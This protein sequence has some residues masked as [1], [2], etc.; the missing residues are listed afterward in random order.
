V[1][2]PDVSLE[3]HLQKSGW[4]SFTPTLRGFPGWI[5]GYGGS[6]SRKSSLKKRQSDKKDCHLRFLQEALK[7]ALK[8]YIQSHYKHG[9]YHQTDQRS[10]SHLRQRYQRPLLP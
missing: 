8:R 4:V 9:H 7:V 3:I 5:E 2:F 6:I 10:R 1:A